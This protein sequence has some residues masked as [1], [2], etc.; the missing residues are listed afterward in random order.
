MK[1]IADIDPLELAR[2]R[3]EWSAAQPMTRQQKRAIVAIV[4]VIVVALI[5]APLRTAQILIGFCTLFYV[6]STLYKFAVIRASL[7]PSAIMRFSPEEIASVE[8]R[9]W[10]IY[11]ILVP[12]YK[13]P[14]TLK[15]MLNALIAMDYPADKKDVQF[16]LEEDDDLT[17]DAARTLTMPPGFRV[18]KIPPSFPRTKPKACNIGLYLAKGEYLVIYDAEDMPETDQ[19]KKAVLA[20]EASPENV[21][22]VQSRL[23]YYNPRQN[24]LTRWFTAEYSAWFDLQLPGLSAMRAV[25]PLGGTSNHFKIDVLRDLMGWDAYNVTEDCDLGV[26][27][28]RAGYATRMLETTTWEEACSVLPFWIKQRT[29]WQKGYI[30]TWFV[31]MRRPWKLARELGFVN[32]LH[33]Q[34]LIGGGPF[35]VL[36]NPIFWAMALV[37]FLFRPEGVSHLFPG[38]IFAAGA[39]CLFLGNFVFI[40]INLLGCCKRKNDDLMWWALLTPIYWLMMSYSGWRALFQFFHD[41]F[42]WEKTQHGLVKGASE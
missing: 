21:V 28:A 18:T 32:F 15:Q 9:E 23:N 10:P 3:P 17:L 4:L 33:Y 35:S 24:V 2:R 27:L 20:F 30:Q 36:I 1:N 7:S 37:W 12:M 5:F 11:S 13:E 38:P 34:L 25:I 8:P 42:V 39:G 31:H 40:Y 29:R 19:L 41:P 6:I 26:R 14:E 16:L 22:C